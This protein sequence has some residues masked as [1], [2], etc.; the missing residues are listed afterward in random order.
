[1]KA[2]KE[3]YNYIE[4]LLTGTK[5]YE[6]TI[7]IAVLSGA[8]ATNYCSVKSQELSTLPYNT[9][10]RHKYHKLEKTKSKPKISTV[11]RQKLLFKYGGTRLPDNYMDWFDG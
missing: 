7:K 3:F 2:N 10:D 9:P 4:D 6:Q 8:Y 11:T 1:M 5:T